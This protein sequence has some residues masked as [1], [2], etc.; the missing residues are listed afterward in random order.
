MSERDDERCIAL[1][2]AGDRC[3]RIPKDGRFCFQ[4][5]E[6]DKTI[7]TPTEEMTFISAISDQ[8]NLR[9]ERFSG[10]QR[11]V[12][13]NLEEIAPDIKN[14]SDLVSSGDFTNALTAYKK[15]AGKTGGGAAKGALVGGVL[16]SPF[17]PIGV[18]TGVT[19]GS[20]FGVYRSI[21]D[22]RAVAARVVDSPPQSATVVDSAHDAIADVQPIQLAIQSAMEQ[23]QSK[24]E[25]LRNTLTRSRD[26]DAVSDVLEQL[27]S[28]RT[29][30]GVTF[31]YIRDQGTEQILEVT[32]GVPVE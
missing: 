27:P 9:P 3:S 26:M 12:A 7:D 13:E 8:V 30:D 25:W 18:A 10:M 16:G 15:S 1:T 19:A 28:Y 32:F 20:W 21:D 17:G 24:T 14:I 6:S 23:P 29:E 2:N 5:N 4:H 11:D 22:D 31:Y